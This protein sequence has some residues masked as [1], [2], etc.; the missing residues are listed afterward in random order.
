DVPI[1]LQGLPDPADP[2]EI[3]D[4]I[5]RPVDRALA[6]L[7]P[8]ASYIGVAVARMIYWRRELK[9][10]ATFCRDPLGLWLFETYPAGSLKLGGKVHEGYKGKVVY[11]AGV[12]LGLE[13]EQGVKLACLLSDLKFRLGTTNQA[14]TQLKSAGRDKLTEAARTLKTAADKLTEA[15][16]KEKDAEAI[17]KAVAEIEEAAEAIKKA[18]AEI[19]EAA[20]AI[21]AAV[22]AMG[23]ADTA[24]EAAAK[25]LGEAATAL[26]ETDGAT[27]D[28]IKEKIKDAY[29]SIGNAGG[30]LK[31]AFG[32]SDEHT[33]THDEFDAALC[34]LAGLFPLDGH[35][36]ASKIAAKQLKLKGPLPQAYVLIDFEE[37]QEVA[38]SQKVDESQKGDESQKVAI[39]VVDLD[40]GSCCAQCPCRQTED[41]SANTNDGSS[42]K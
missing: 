28:E 19:E 3:A 13:N 34:A 11:V 39:D 37:L 35:R 2:L 12:W 8:V 4:L 33:L 25:A 1:D 14:T 23:E 36:L 17:K 22:A 29:T 26:K 30:A 9:K 42:G 40:E 18:V 16:T 41:M 31:E 5:K 15:L 7:A 20:K 6:A 10:K 27:K 38:K 24:L 32:C 21:N